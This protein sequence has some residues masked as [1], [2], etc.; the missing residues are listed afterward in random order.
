MHNY[1]NTDL[2]LHTKLFLL[3]SGNL[4][5][6]KNT[7]RLVPESVWKILHSYF[8]KAPEF[9]KTTEPCNLCR[10]SS[11]LNNL[12]ANVTRIFYILFKLF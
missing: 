6:E 1:L 3:K 10:V 7:R 12:L 4:T 9:V 2:L 8:P 5:I 11:F